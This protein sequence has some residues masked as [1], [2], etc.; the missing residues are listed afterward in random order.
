MHLLQLI[1]IRRIGDRREMKDRVERS[2]AELLMPVECRQILRNEVSAVAGQILEITRA[3]IVNHRN[4]RVLESFLQSQRE[5]RP[6]ETGAAGDNKVR[7][8]V[9]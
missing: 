4:P 2:V 7:R 9:S 6:D 8:R 1:V 3:K 5:I